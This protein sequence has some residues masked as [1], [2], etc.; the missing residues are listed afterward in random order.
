MQSRR[1]SLSEAAANVVAGLALSFIL[2]L[3]LFN[4]MGITASISQNLL[5]TAA[6]SALSIARGYLIRRLFN[7]WAFTPSWLRHT[8]SVDSEP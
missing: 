2:Q 5:I 7:G 3:A 8:A 4:V 1:A 6:F